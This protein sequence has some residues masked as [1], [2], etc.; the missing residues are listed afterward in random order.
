MVGLPL[1]VLATSR[2][3]TLRNSPGAS[4]S[5]LDRKATRALWGGLGWRRTA[6]SRLSGDSGA[7]MG[8][9]LAGFNAKLAL[10]RPLVGHL[11]TAFGSCSELPIPAHFPVS[12]LFGLARRGMPL[13]GG[14]RGAMP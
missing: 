1:D 4:T 7:G 3:M 2:L 10:D 6:R 14:Q 8:I 11:I 12:P 9:S 13:L 5:S